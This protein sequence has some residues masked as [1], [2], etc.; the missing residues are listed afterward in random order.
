MSKY[1]ELKPCPFCGGEGCIQRHEFVG[2]TDT[3][4]IVCLDCGCETRQFYDTKKDVIKLWNRRADDAPIANRPQGEWEDTG[5]DP[6]H[7]H[8]LTAIWYRC[9]ECG[10]GTNTKTNYCPECGA[11][12]KQ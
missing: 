8:P 4:G 1:D 7:S 2:Y 6:S 12:M 5:K 11:K 3:F 10:Y 9:S